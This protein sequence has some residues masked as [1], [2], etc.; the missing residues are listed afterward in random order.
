MPL[1]FSM[2]GGGFFPLLK[3]MQEDL[4]NFMFTIFFYLFCVLYKGRQWVLTKHHFLFSQVPFGAKLVSRQ[5]VCLCSHL[6]LFQSTT[7]LP[8]L[9]LS[10]WAVTEDLT[11]FVH[12]IIPGL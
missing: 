9:P 6:Q 4:Q 8:G 5:F 1:Y 3:I 10:H 7:K 2:F 11:Q 12:I